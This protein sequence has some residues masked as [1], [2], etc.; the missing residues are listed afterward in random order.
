MTSVSVLS[1]LAALGVEH[2]SSAL[3]D[4][5]LSDQV[6]FFSA[7]GVL[8][9]GFYLPRL[10][11]GFNIK[12]NVEEGSFVDAPTSKGASVVEDAVVDLP[13]WALWRL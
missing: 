12:E 4:R 6:A 5:P 8:E 2:P 7:I 13:C 1:T 9:A 3:S 11:R 10:E